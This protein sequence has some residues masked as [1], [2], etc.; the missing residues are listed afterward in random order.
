MEHLRCPKCGME[1]DKPVC[2]LCGEEIIHHTHNKNVLISKF[3]PLPTKIVI[4][5]WILDSFYML[6]SE[7][8]TFGQWLIV[9]IF[10]ILIYGAITNAVYYFW[11]KPRKAQKSK[12]SKTN[13]NKTFYSEINSAK[14][15]RQK[16]FDAMEGHE[17]EYFC[18]DI[19]KKNEYEDVEVT[20]GSGDQG[21]DI[22]AYKEGIKYG[23]QCKCY[24]SDIGNKA[25]QE[26]F[27]GKTFYGCHVAV[28]LTNRYFTKSA[29]E[30]AEK[31]GVLLWDRDKL[32]QLVKNTTI[33]NETES[34]TENPTYE[35]YE[36]TFRHIFKSNV[37]NIS[38]KRLLPKIKEWKIDT[39]LIVTSSQCPVCQKYNRKIYSFY[40][41]NKK[42]PKLPPMLYNH[43][44]PTCGCSIG[45]SIFFPG[46][47]TNP[48]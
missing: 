38:I 26:A 4:A 11:W 37:D 39:L 43:K 48:K 2:P 8:H 14:E 34:D 23:I 44:C 36:N 10:G 30:L 31:N 1:T 19:L 41:W 20:K 13:E 46:I 17:F 24:S 42:Y 18:A 29:R 12:H 9:M 16:S 27:S 28:V 25:V 21:I 22:I 15:C 47:N 35:G 33:V 6:F 45:A 7:N 40:G 5:L 3:L 32:V